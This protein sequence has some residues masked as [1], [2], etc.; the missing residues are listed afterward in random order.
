LGINCKY[1]G[2]HNR[3]QEV[4]TRCL[5]V[6]CIPI[7]PEQLGGL[8][9]PRIPAEIIGG[10]GNDVLDGKARVINQDGQDVTSYFLKGA[11]E[12]KK[13]AQLF[14]V[15]EAILKEHSPSCGV[16]NI[17]TGD[18]CGNLK[19]GMGVTTASLKRLGIKISSEKDLEGRETLFKSN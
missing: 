6:G 12:V 2:G 13:I 17:Y 1:N 8:A 19:P 3:Q 14:S 15:Q 5:K 16:K 11:E 4:I 10:D 7:C 18:F 9:T